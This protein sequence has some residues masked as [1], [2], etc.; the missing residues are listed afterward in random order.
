MLKIIFKR[1]KEK[2][3]PICFPLQKKERKNHK[4]LLLT[5]WLSFMVNFF[6][7]FFFEIFKRFFPTHVP[8][9]LY[10]W[11]KS[12]NFFSF[13]TASSSSLIFTLFFS[14]R[15]NFIPI[16]LFDWLVDNHNN[17]N[18]DDDVILVFFNPWFKLGDCF[19]FANYFHHHHN[20][21]QTI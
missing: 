2:N 17:N 13:L 1:R 5:W 16:F 3:N 9:S 15:N 10:F 6:F 18:D 21:Q 8:S 14:F 11:K 7:G 20:Y 12:Q 19:F 4:F